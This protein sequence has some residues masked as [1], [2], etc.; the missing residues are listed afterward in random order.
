MRA[1]T[2]GGL[3]TALLCGA[4]TLV[5]AE[6]PS[7]TSSN[8]LPQVTVQAQ[9]EALAEQARQFVG[10]VSG[11]SWATA[12]DHPL[13]LWRSPV[14]VAVAGLRPQGEFIF[15]RF[16]EIITD[17]G[18]TVGTNGC[19]PNL[20][21]VLTTKPEA[22]L[23]AWR[24]RDQRM[25]G[26]AN[27]GLVNQFFTHALPVRVWY[28]TSFAGRDAAPGAS[29][30]ALSSAATAGGGAMAGGA[31]TS[32][33][34]Q[35]MLLDI[36]TFQDQPGGTRLSLTAVPDL[37]STIVVVDLKQCEGFGWGALTDYIAM[38][39]LTNVDLSTN[40]VDMPSV[41]AL[42]SAPADKRLTG[43]TD[44]DRAYLK[45]VYHSRRMARL[46]RVEIREQMVREMDTSVAS[47]H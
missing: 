21:V 36:P 28:N 34:T 5:Q 8:S 1:R 45:A 29:S 43:M 46:Q 11:S 12:V 25:F 31:G 37:S 3:S 26:G 47:A 10:K 16:T 4:A 13:E 6:P 35:L 7:A 19:T 38:V 24:K 15:K 40:F 41:L 33:Q 27:P 2:F 44:W 18:A 23:S 17:V 20:I 14:C 39:S 42:F 9:R 30:S 22:F 32:T